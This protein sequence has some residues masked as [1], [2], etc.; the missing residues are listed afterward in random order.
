MYG[1]K[2]KRL[3][4]TLDTSQNNMS[5]RGEGGKGG[6]IGNT[7]TSRDG[8]K[9]VMRRAFFSYIYSLAVLKN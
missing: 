6:K 5:S 7:K 4:T 1:E 2:R 3:R 8:F 9:S